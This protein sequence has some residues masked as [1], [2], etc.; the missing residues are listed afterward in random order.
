M[1]QA[2]YDDTIRTHTQQCLKLLV[3]L[4]DDTLHVHVGR[5]AYVHKI[6]QYFQMFYFCYRKSVG[7]PE[8]GCAQEMPP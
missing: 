5:V 2:E 3:K 4:T 7:A 8:K 1:I 6:Y